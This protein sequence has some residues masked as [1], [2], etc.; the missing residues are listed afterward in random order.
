MFS[1]FFIERPIFAW[2]VSIVIVLVGGVAAFRLPIAQYPDI[3]PPT[4]QVSAIYPG[5]NAQ[6][7][8]DSVAAPIE[9]QVNGV[10]RMMYMSS[11]CTNDG[12][13]SLTITFELGTDLN[14]AQ[15]LVQNRVALAM[16]QL[17]SQVQVQGVTTKK[18]SPSILLAVNLIS[19]H[20][21]LD[22]LYLSNYATI[23]IKDELLRLPGVGD[24][25]YLGQ[26]DYS[27][28]VWLD[29]QRMASRNL[30]ASEVVRAVQNQNVQVAAGQ[31]GR[32]PM[33]PGQ[34]FQFTMST[35]GRLLDRSQFENIII[36]TGAADA[37][38]GDTSS[39]VV[40]LRDVARVELGA[41]QYDQICRLDGQPSVGLAVFQLPGS[42]ALAVANAVKATMETLKKR[43]P[44]DLDY[45][46]VYDTTPFIDQSIHEVFKTLGEAILLVAIVVLFFLQDWKAMILPMIDVPV[47]LVGTFA[48]MAI[49]GFSLNNLTLFGMVLAIGIVVDDAI[50]VLEN[51]ERQLSF[52]L[53]PKTATIRAMD[54][55]TGPIIAITLV[56]CAVFLPSV[57]MPGVTGQFF[58]QFALVISS[59]MVI[60][61]INALTLTP[62]R[63]V[64]IFSSEELDEHGHPRREALPW[65][66]FAILG[67]LISAKL[68]H[69]PMM[70]WL[71]IS[72]GHDSHGAA[73]S[74]GMSELLSW[75]VFA[76]AALPGLIAGGVL[77][78]IVIRPVNK[79]LARLF[80]AF[81]RLFDRLT[82]FYGQT[83]A[84]LLRVSAIVMLVYVGLLFLTGW[85]MNRAP[86]GFIPTQD[87][88]YLLVNVQLPDS[89][90]VQRTKQVMAQIDRIALGSA[91]GK[92]RTPGVIHTL[93][94]AGQSFLLNANGSNF[95]SC[96]VILDDFSKRH[97]AAEYDEAVA[98]TLRKR[99]AAEID[100]AQIQ[101]FRAPPIQGL[102][103]AGGFKVQVEQRGYSDLPALQQQCEQLVADAGSDRR[104]VGLFSMFRAGTPQIFLDIDRSKC[105][106]LG[107]NVNE[108]FNTLEVYM[109][110]YFINLFNAFGRTWQVNMMAESRFRNRASDLQQLQVRNAAGQMVPLGTL[111][112]SESV[113]GPVM[114]IRYNMYPS[115]PVVG[116]PAPG[117]SSGDVVRIIEN[118]GD[119]A[120]IVSEWT[121]IMYLQLQEGSGAIVVFLVGS[122]LVFFVLAAKYESW[123]LP[124]AVIL[125]V[126][127]CLLCSVEGMMLVALPVDIFVQIGFLVLVGLA[128][129]NAILI[130]EFAAQMAAEG[131]PVFEATVEA[132]RL[133]LR[134]IVM[135]SLAFILGVVPLMIGE[136]A[137]AEMRRSLGTA[138]FAG[139][140]GVTGFGIILTPIFFY[141]ILRRSPPKPAAADHTK[142]AGK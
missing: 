118:K 139:M 124:M 38:Q 116:N 24:L 90:S 50:V 97:T 21:S 120:G 106:L 87:Q 49:L 40:R 84:R 9:Q 130:V 30:T 36:K 45:R 122:A 56:L 42:N 137:G 101:V 39:Q 18:K 115:A 85:S 113:G 127:M 102:G 25:S 43:F 140:I 51:V 11:Q 35:L 89:A 17:P 2:V 134:P 63:A 73:A 117:T 112:K 121:E 33:L 96:F 133:R 26:R 111:V 119:Q 80:G 108:V 28:R 100:G 47:S 59:A 62:S 60:S 69:D 92:D 99:F 1:R 32:E 3:T 77:G 67:G 54:E 46:I 12:A 82:V 66:I 52:G 125:V 105:Q 58:R 76:A 83:I 4:V 14:M 98:Q 15:V 55:I 65:W 20:H 44:K 72:M 104:L 91:D 61:A 53:D 27:M 10:E 109:G 75:L 57:F 29:P 114:V 79:A 81:N 95:G 71:G 41:Q 132:A 68:L 7:V 74:R 8:A 34:Q 142:P 37:T 86:K 136:G 16:P 6:V 126:P 13:Y 107:V 31:I 141:V 88:G 70:G 103:T 128:A 129:K 123:K 64:A 131:K 135:T 23:Q 19:P 110:G 5:A 22:D 93:S 138:V 78:K 94:I 48:I